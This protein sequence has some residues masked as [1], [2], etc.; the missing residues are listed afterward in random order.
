MSCGLVTLMQ[1]AAAQQV[2]MLEVHFGAIRRTYHE[3]QDSDVNIKKSNHCLCTESDIT[4]SVGY[5]A[6]FACICP[7]STSFPQWPCIGSLSRRYWKP[8][9]ISGILYNA[10]CLLCHS[11]VTL[12]RSVCL[13]LCSIRLSP[14][15]LGTVAVQSRLDECQ[16]LQD[17]V[18]HHHHALAQCE[19]LSV[20]F[21]HN[22]IVV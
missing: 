6:H 10:A 20:G 7:H 16:G 18:K 15:L 14:C 9:T 8:H 22:F 2:L 21:W 11:S 5:R 1:S 17:R 19:A 3:L 12:C 4:Q 13:S